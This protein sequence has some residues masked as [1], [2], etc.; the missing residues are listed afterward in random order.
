MLL[1]P[2]AVVV[3]AFVLQEV[4]VVPVFAAVS[5]L[6]VVVLVSVVL[7]FAAQASVAQVSA[8]VL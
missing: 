4:V 8:V 1:K 5:V 6:V 7:V 3:P 2:A